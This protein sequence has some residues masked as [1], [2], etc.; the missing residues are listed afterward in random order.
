MTNAKKISWFSLFIKIIIVFVT[1]LIMAWLVGK[2]INKNNLS[3][4]FKNNINNMEEA[5][6]KYFKNIDLPTEKGKSKKI[7]LEEMEKEG[8]IEKVNSKNGATCNTKKSY[9]KI[10]RKKDNYLVET[11]LE[12]GKESNTIT[13]KF[14]LEDCKNCNSNEIENINNEDNTTNIDDN[15]NNINNHVVEEKNNITYYEYVKETISYSNWM[16]GDKTGTNIENRYEYYSIA[17]K[18]YYSIGIVSEKSIKNN[19][20]EYILKL[21]NVP[22]KDYYYTKI[23]S[24]NYFDKNELNNYINE[25]DISMV[26]SKEINISNVENYMLKKDNFTYTLTPYYNKGQFYVKVKININNLNNVDKYYDNTTNSGIY[27]IPIKLNIHF[28]NGKVSETKPDGEYEII[29][30]YRYIEVNKEIKWSS[31]NYLEGYVKTGNSK[32]Q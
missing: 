31:E 15:N 12:C 13:R 2:I 23:T 17:N 10:I 8:L 28:D 24:S 26:N 19:H 27:L 32:V 11:F 9:S 14:A 4:T 1:I 30:Y 25:K 3:S 21:N 6:I 16:T 5:A 22:N 20:I 29:S 18:E 7:T